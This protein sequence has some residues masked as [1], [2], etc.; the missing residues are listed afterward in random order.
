MYLHLIRGGLLGDRLGGLQVVTTSYPLFEFAT[1][2]DSQI[3][4][5]N[6][7]PK[8]VEPHDYEPTPQDIV[9][10]TKADLLIYNGNGLE[11]WVDDFLLTKEGKKIRTLNISHELEQFENL[12]KNDPHFW[13]DPLIAKQ[14]V[15]IIS[16]ELSQISPT[17][18]DTIQSNMTNY[19]AELGNLHNEYLLGLSNCKQNKIIVSHDAFE[20]LAKRY[21]FEVI[22]ISGVTPEEEPSPKRLAEIIELAKEEDIKYIFYESLVSPN[23][24]N[25]IASEVGA[26]TLVLNPIENLTEEEERQGANYLSI[27]RSNLVN[28]KLAMQCQ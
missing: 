22:S 4:V 6:L 16:K 23:L 13:L 20:Y 8:G 18:S 11:P 26:K 14:I 2:L 9:N 7:V 5:I 24:A 27:M 10:I 17:L 3:D 1:N 21:H 28:L 12:D 19:V 15:T 25:M